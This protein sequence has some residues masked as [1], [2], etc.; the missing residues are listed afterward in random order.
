VTRSKK[1][2]RSCRLIPRAAAGKTLYASGKLVAP[3]QTRH[4]MTVEVFI[5]AALTDLSMSPLA[6]FHTGAL[7]SLLGGRVATVKDVVSI[8]PSG[9]VV[10]CEVLDRRW[11]AR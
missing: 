10:R 6:E 7:L 3:E 11:A 9:L 2:G 4:S 1:A 5:P 8:E